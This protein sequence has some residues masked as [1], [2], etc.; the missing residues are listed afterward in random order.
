MYFK[1][2]LNRLNQIYIPIN[3]EH[4]LF[5]CGDMNAGESSNFHDRSQSVTVNV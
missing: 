4:I 1:K 2:D 3:I 5:R